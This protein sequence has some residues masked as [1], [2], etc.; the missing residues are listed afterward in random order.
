MGR[1][2]HQQLQSHV[3]GWFKSPPKSG[4]QSDLHA[5]TF[6]LFHWS[7]LNAMSIYCMSTGYCDIMA[8]GHKRRLLQGNGSINKFSQQ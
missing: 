1:H 8:E 6:Q 3:N 5:S 4:G 2:F 7:A